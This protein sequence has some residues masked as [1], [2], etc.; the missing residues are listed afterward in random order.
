[1]LY[2][3]RNAADNVTEIPKLNSCCISLALGILGPAPSHNDLLI[4]AVDKTILTQ[5]GYDTGRSKFPISKVAES[6][7]RS[8]NFDPHLYIIGIEI[9][10]SEPAETFGRRN[11]ALNVTVFGSVSIGVASTSP[12]TRSML[13]LML[14][15]LFVRTEERDGNVVPGGRLIDAHFLSA[16]NS[17]SHFCNASPLINSS[18]V[19]MKGEMNGSSFTRGGKSEVVVMIPFDA[20]QQDCLARTASRSRVSL[21]TQ[22]RP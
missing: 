17:R 13:P 19:G 16:A 20:S 14:D 8:R 4:I 18:R 9:L 5:S 6:A 10:R 12:V 11:A 3:G 7:P 22:S 15:C 1:V 2:R 21:R